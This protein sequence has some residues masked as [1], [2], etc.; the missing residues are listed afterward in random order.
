MEM[1][2][3]SMN[4]PIGIPMSEKIVNP[5]FTEYQFEV[6]ENSILITSPKQRKT[7]IM[8]QSYNHSNQNQSFFY[9]ANE[10]S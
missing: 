10:I 5:I 3:F 8:D 7:S 4:L 6:V 2:L 1:P 9:N